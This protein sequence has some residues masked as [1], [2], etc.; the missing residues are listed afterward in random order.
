VSLDDFGERYVDIR[1]EHPKIITQNYWGIYQ[2]MNIFGGVIYVF[3]CSFILFLLSKVIGRGIIW[4]A[5][6]V[7]MA[8]GL[9]WIMKLPPLTF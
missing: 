2:I 7:I 3:A 4:W 8:I 5:I 9:G 6:A 1:V